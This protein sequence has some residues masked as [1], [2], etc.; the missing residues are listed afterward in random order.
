MSLLQEGNVV[1]GCLQSS[2]KVF[3]LK[4]SKVASWVSYKLRNELSEVV[5]DISNSIV[6]VRVRQ[7]KKEQR[8]N[9]TESQKR[10]DEAERSLDESP[11]PT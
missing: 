9:G 6:A 11:M 2:L 1:F 3:Y 4:W 7:G 5:S 10:Q 8:Q